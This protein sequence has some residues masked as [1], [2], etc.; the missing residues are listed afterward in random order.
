MDRWHITSVQKL[1][2]RN[3]SFKEYAHIPGISKII[4]EV[5]R[6]PV[7]A[8]SGD[9]TDYM[10]GKP[11][12]INTKC[13]WR[14]KEGDDL[15]DICDALYMSTRFRSDE[16][17]TNGRFPDPRTASTRPDARPAPAGLPSNLYDA[18]YLFG[19]TDEEKRKL[20]MRPDFS[21]LIPVE[22]LR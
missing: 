15:F 7:D 11:Y 14:S 19:L 1:E 21:F 8:M 18:Q 2:R 5:E 20:D 22:L 17:P 12:L 16:R 13:H 3:G 4:D 10:D 9:E 6:I